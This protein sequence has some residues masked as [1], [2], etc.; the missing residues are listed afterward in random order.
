MGRAEIVKD[1]KNQW[2][3][4]ALE[5]G[6]S[7]TNGTICGS[8]ECCATDSAHVFKK[9]KIQLTETPDQIFL[10]VNG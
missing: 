7:R 8:M 5:D 2:T 1:N 10:E 6:Y 4:W 9:K 3:R